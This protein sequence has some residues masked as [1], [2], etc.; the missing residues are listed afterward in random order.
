MYVFVALTLHEV[1]IN[2]RVPVALWVRK[3]SQRLTA[4]EGQCFDRQ[5]QVSPTVQNTVNS[6]P[7]RLFN[8]HFSS[9]AEGQNFDKR[10]CRCDGSEGWSLSHVYQVLRAQL[11]GKK[12]N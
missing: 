4:A 6:N 9:Q 8:C 11:L 12:N 5:E 1:K 2:G 10:L 7:P 3:P